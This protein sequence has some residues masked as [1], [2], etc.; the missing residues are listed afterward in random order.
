VT[1]SAFFPMNSGKLTFLVIGSCLFLILTSCRYFNQNEQ[2]T[3]KNEQLIIFHAGSLS[4]PVKEI[5]D[6]FNK[7]H[8]DVQILTEAAGSVACARKITDLNKSCDVL[9]S[10]DYQVIDNFLIPKFA[11]WNL[12]FASNEM[13]LVFTDKSK[14]SN[15]ITNKNWPENISTSQILLSKSLK[16]TSVLSGQKKLI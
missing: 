10:A 8:P 5:I 15:E 9:L 1:I 11:T 16:K 7:T 13:A 4:I 2:S 12:K 3:A 14:F 6:A